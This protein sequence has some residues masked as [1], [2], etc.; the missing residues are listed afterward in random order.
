MNDVK[1]T[2]LTNKYKYTLPDC[3]IYLYHTDEYF[4]LPSYP[5]SI[6]DQLGST[7]ASD[8]ALSRTAPIYSYTSSGPRTINI[9]LKL[10]RD[11]MNAF[12][13]QGSNVRINESNG[14]ILTSVTDDYVDILVKKLQAIAL[15]RYQDTDKLVNPPRVALRLG[16]EIFIKGIVNSGITI[17]YGLPLLDTNKYATIDI[18]FSISEAQPFDAD[19][20]GKLGSFRGLTSGLKNKVGLK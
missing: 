6:S 17:S 1:N 3:Y 14:D 7:F 13:K 4:I 5:D 12:N 15:P 16:Q 2:Y 18:S 19:S 11:M 8:T 10:R 9:S 20:V